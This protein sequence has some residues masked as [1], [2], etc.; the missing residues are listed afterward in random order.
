MSSVK[1][2]AHGFLLLQS[3]ADE[4]EKRDKV[5]P[6]NKNIIDRIRG[7]NLDAKIILGYGINNPERVKEAVAAGADG[8][9]VGTAMIERITNGNFEVLSK[10]IKEMKKATLP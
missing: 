6:E 3:F 5:A 8:V 1:N 4:M 7:T 2:K 9:I 10:F